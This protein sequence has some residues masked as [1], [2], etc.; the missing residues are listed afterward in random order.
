[1]EEELRR[2]IS[3]LQSELHAERKELEKA[4]SEGAAA[5][6]SRSASDSEL[7]QARRDLTGEKVESDR[8]RGHSAGLE[9]ELAK[10]KAEVESFLTRFEDQ[11]VRH[12]ADIKDMR[13]DHSRALTDLREAFK[14]LSADALRQVQPEFLRLANETLGKFAESAKG[15]LS[16]RQQSI[17]TLV[18]P[19]EEQLQTY[20]QRLQQAETTQSNLLGEVRKQLEGLT[21]QSQSLSGETLNSDACSARI[22]RGVDGVRKPCDESW[23]PRE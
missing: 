14:A 12:A 4:K 17:A 22:R 1:M 18:K 11:R 20:Q 15:D 2:Q 6:A 13:E 19:L 8:L 10:A 5:N 9:R 23:R 7:T 21:A 3:S 16:Q